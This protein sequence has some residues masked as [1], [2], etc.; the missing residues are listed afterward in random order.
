MKETVILFGANSAIARAY[1]S[2]LETL[3]R[4]IQLICISRS[5]TDQ[6]KS[7]TVKLAYFQSDYSKDSLTNII[8]NLKKNTILTQAIIFNGQ[9]H[10]KSKMPEKKLSELDVDYFQDI[11]TANALIPIQCVSSLWPLLNHKTPCT[12]VAFSAR[13]GSIEDNKLGG[14]YSYRASK[15]ALNMLFKSAAIEIERK[16]KLTKLILFHPGT[17][18]T[19][20]S[21][22]F[23]KSVI[24][25]QLFSTEFVA[26]QLLE[27]QQKKFTHQSNREPAFIDWKGEDIPW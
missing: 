4:S 20:L 23:H 2:Q 17:T 15:A 5:S 8:A 22:P 21:K 12:I 3:N 14:W 6:I 24:N 1:I 25:G 16:A 9:L 26:R 27:I 18:D 7:D 11:M 19:E 10:V 13:V